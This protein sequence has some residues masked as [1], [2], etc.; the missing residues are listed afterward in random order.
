MHMTYSIIEM[1]GASENLTAQVLYVCD[2]RSMTFK[3][4]KYFCHD[5]FLFVVFF[6]FL[7]LSKY[8]IHNF[9]KIL[10]INAPDVYHYNL[11][12]SQPIFSI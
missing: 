7:C 5:I 12:K 4:W 2:L 10:I 11:A 8:R 3:G 1:L 6:R 9:N